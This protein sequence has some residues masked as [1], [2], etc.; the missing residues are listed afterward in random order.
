M[1]L[2]FW[3]PGF[4]AHIID[5]YYLHFSSPMLHWFVNALPSGNSMMNLFL[6]ALQ[7]Q[8][9]KLLCKSSKERNAS[10]MVIP[11]LMS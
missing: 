8:Y 6:Y 3:L 9:L 7:C 11:K 5:A 10:L 1:S 4:V 2:I